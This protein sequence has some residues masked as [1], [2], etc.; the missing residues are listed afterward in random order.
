[1][2]DD[3]DTAKINGDFLK[4]KG[5]EIILPP[6]LNWRQCTETETFDLILMDIQARDGNGLDYTRII[7]KEK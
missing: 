2:E 3:C 6:I 7:S 4:E 5:Y 1:M